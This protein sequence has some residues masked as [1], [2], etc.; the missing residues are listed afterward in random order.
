M[1]LDSKTFSPPQTE[2]CYYKAVTP[3]SF[4][5]PLVITNPLCISMNLLA[6]DSS[7]LEYIHIDI[8]F[9]FFFLATLGLWCCT[10]AFSSCGKRGLLSSSGAWG[11]LCRGSSCGTWVLGNMGFSSGACAQQVWVGAPGHRISHC[12][13]WAQL[14]RGIILDQGSNSCPMHHKVGSSPL[15]TREAP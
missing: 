4:P 5:Q 11:S 12:S 6:L 10:W 3:V 1:T 8:L 7:C 13:T 15:T 9:F 14:P 2:L